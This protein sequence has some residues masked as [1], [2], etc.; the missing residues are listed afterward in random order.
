[1]EASRYIFLNKF[2]KFLQ[3]NASNRGNPTVLCPPEYM[4]CFLH[5]LITA[6]RACWDEYKNRNASARCS[7]GKK[8]H[9]TRRP[10]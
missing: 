1:G 10:S 4:V 2:R 3:E 9:P 5:R 6:V 8:H 7:D